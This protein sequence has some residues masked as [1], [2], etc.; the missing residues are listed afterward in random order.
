MQ[1]SFGSCLKRGWWFI[2]LAGVH[3]SSYGSFFGGIVLGV[4]IIFFYFL[5]KEKFS[6]PKTSQKE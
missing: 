4:T 3:G 1:K 2:L 5:I 6:K